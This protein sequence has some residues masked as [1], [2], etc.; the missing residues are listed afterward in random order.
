MPSSMQVD[1]EGTGAAKEAPVEATAEVDA[2]EEAEAA[3]LDEGSDDL[4]HT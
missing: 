1:H 4:T 2:E 3:E